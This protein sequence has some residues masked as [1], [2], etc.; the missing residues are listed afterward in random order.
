MTIAADD[1]KERR[2]Y[3]RYP[4]ANLK[5]QAK[6][7]KGLFGSDWVDMEVSD[8]SSH[9]IALLLDEQPTLDQTITLRLVLEMDMGAIKI[10]KI[11]AE[12][13]N[14][15]TVNERWRLGLEFVEDKNA[16]KQEEIQKQLERVQQIL[17][18]NA[19]V[20]ERLKK[21]VT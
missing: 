7:K 4:A 17:E 5:V 14:K 12:P 1:V 11:D 6:T 8:F 18:K 19:A 16:S 10:D 21:Q 3:R 15:V 9:G 2:R 20:N 13:R